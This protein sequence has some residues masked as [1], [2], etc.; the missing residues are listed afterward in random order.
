MCASSRSMLTRRSVILGFTPL[1]AGQTLEREVGITTASLSR[2]LALQPAGRQVALLDLPRFMRQELDM[3][4]ID[5]NTRTLEG[6]TRQQLERLR[7]NAA[8]QG[9]SLIHI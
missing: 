2:H 3:R 1:A 6:A 7:S 9:L 4:V 5:L 8:A